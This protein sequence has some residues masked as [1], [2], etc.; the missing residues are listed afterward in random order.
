M[1][2]TGQGALFYSMEAV[3]CEILFLRSARFL[4]YSFC[5]INTTYTYP[6]IS[7]VQVLSRLYIKTRKGHHFHFSKWTFV[8]ANMSD[9][10][11][12][13]VLLCCGSGWPAVCIEVL[14]KVDICAFELVIVRW[15]FCDFAISN[16]WW[17]RK[18]KF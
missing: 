8:L 3:A 4:I 14:T 18:A 13:V 11:T 17:L 9:Y 15:L 6:M 1:F 2:G 12:S 10:L 7:D 5:F 16:L